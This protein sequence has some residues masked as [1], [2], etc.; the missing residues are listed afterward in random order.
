LDQWVVSRL[1]LLSDR[2]LRHSENVAELTRALAKAHGLNAEQAYWAGLAHDLAREWSADE[3][4]DEA[5]QLG[6][7]IDQWEQAEPLLLHGPVVATWMQRDRVGSAPIWDAI[8]Y[9]TTASPGI[10]G[11]A[12]ALFIADE[13]EPARSYPEAT[14]LRRQALKDFDGGY[15][16]V[17]EASVR[18]LESQGREVHPRMIQALAEVVDG[19]GTAG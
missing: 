6:L 15:R 1:A 19:P 13:T 14:R 7:S 8:R 5:K 11:L 4:L 10:Q 3:L 9:H 12:R 2:R 17:L 16:A 18:Y